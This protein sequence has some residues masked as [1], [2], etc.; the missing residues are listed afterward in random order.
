MLVHS[1]LSSQTLFSPTHIAQT[2]SGDTI[3]DRG[4]IVSLTSLADE[5]WKEGEVQEQFLPLQFSFLIIFASAQTSTKCLGYVPVLGATLTNGQLS[6]R[7]CPN[8]WVKTQR[9]LIYSFLKFQLFNLKKQ[10]F[11]NFLKHKYG[12]SYKV[13]LER[14]ITYSIVLILAIVSTKKSQSALY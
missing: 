8:I 3:V 7:L 9:R 10:Y 4:F 1:F 11:S 12:F 5:P 6:T 13:S 2:D 14:I